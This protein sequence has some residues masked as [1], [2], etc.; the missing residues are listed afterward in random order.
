MSEFPILFFNIR[1]PSAMTTNCFFLHIVRIKHCWLLSWIFM[2]YLLQYFASSVIFLE[3]G[4]KTFLR[5]TFL[6]TFR[7]RVFFNFWITFRFSVFNKCY[8]SLC[9]I[10]NIKYTYFFCAGILIINISYFCETRSEGCSQYYSRFVGFF[11]R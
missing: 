9:Y 11:S 3:T 8:S 5:M 4:L 6:P 2:I 7:H 10:V 1:Y